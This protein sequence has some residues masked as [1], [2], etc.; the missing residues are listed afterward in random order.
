MLATDYADTALCKARPGRLQLTLLPIWSHNSSY[1]GSC[2]H[3][4]LRNP[5]QIPCLFH[6]PLVSFDPAHLYRSGL[7]LVRSPCYA[8][9]LPCPLYPA[10][11]AFPRPTSQAEAAGCWVHRSKPVSLTRCHWDARPFRDRCCRRSHSAASSKL[12][13]TKSWLRKKLTC[14]RYGVSWQSPFPCPAHIDL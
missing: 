1:E 8:A 11:Q 12:L 5:P 10:Y 3:L 14:R 4:R 6:H 13:C 7:S 9:S 2:Y